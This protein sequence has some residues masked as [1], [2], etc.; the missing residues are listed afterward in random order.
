[1]LGDFTLGQY[2]PSK[3]VIHKIDPRFK[4]IFLIALIV[5]IYCA[6]N[7]FSLAFITVTVLTVLLITKVPISTYLKNLKIILPILVLT[8]LLNLF[9]M[10]DGNVLAQF[11]IFKITY[12]GVYRSVFMAVRLVLL[13]LISSSLTYTTTPN[14][15]TD[16]L[17]NLMSPLKLIGLGNAVHVLFLM[18]TIALRFIPTLAEETEKI[19]NAQKARGAD[20][21]SG[22][23]I[24][25]VK[26]I[27]PIII[28]LLISSVRRA[29]DLAEAM[30]CR[31]YNGGKGKTRMNVLKLRPLDFYSLAVIVFLI[32]AVILINLI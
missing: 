12:D 29:Y 9:Y 22:K 24:D 16:A 28:P 21:E 4:I 14:E 13:I 32:A 26:S 27:I 2:Y 30:E 6:A 20:F 8:F 18:M 15:L 25:R 10:G 31:C 17:E 23:L 7:V 19:I 5:L 3:S 11:W 1:M